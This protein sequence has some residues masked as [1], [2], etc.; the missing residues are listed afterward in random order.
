MRR[1]LILV[2]EHQAE[3]DAGGG[4]DELGHDPADE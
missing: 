1:I 2:H 3:Q 4:A